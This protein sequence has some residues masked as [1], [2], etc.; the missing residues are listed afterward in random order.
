VLAATV[1]PGLANQAS[2]DENRNHCHEL[3]ERS[4]LRFIIRFQED[5]LIVSIGAILAS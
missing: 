1:Y 4:G 3:H 2:D 5:G